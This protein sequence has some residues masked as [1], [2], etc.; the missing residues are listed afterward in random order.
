LITLGIDIG[1]SATKAIVLEDGSTTVASVMVPAGAGTSG[2]QRVIE[3]LKKVS[4]YELA[5]MDYIIATGYGRALFE[6]ANRHVSELTCHA[7]GVSML[8]PQTRTI[9]DIGGQDVKVLRVNETGNMLDFVM[10]EKCAAG[11]GRFLE[12]M[13]RVLETEVSKLGELAGQSEKR[14]DISSTCTVFAE[15][16]VISQLANGAKLPDIAAGIHRSVAK[17]V[18]G[19]ANR[20]GIKPQLAMTGGVAR[21][22]GVVRAIEE[23]L[24]Y[25]VIVPPMPQMTGA[26]G[27]ARLAY[28]EASGE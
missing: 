20:I 17:S 14:L 27:A 19:L 22:V 16:E 8:L 9:I 13:A 12:V 5:Q 11:T 3:E 1:S 7:K 23:R 2:T 6:P 24:G 25:P 28:Q 21:N 26:L 18:C 4:G 15:S 10:N